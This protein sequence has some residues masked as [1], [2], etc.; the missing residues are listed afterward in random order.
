MRTLIS[1]EGIPG[2]GKS[3]VVN[4]LADF[5]TKI[6]IVLE[7]VAA[8]ERMGLLAGMYDG[9]LCQGCFQLMALST[10]ACS[11]IAGFVDPKTTTVISERSL[12]SDSLFATAR[13]IC[14]L[15]RV[16]YD[17]AYS[18]LLEA[19]G[20]QHTVRILIDITPEVACQR[21]S[22][23]GRA[24]ESSVSLEYLKKLHG[25]HKAAKYAIIIDGHQAPAGVLKD[26]REAIKTISF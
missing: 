11:I 25:L 3:T 9:S 21:L 6:P 17:L 12:W 16:N 1:I 7:P 20:L 19:L 13:G 2:A 23:R 18:S 14:G 10:R 24:S 22:A 8:W 4:G 15:D 26:A 5:D